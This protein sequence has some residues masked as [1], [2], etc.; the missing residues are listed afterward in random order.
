[1]RRQDNLIMRVD[2]ALPLPLAP[3]LIAFSPSPLVAAAAAAS[4]NILISL[5][6]AF[7][8]SSIQI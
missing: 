4:M 8:R 5:S 1:M 7:V 3:Y 6:R 2:G